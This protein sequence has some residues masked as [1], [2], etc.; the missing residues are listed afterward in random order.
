MAYMDRQQVACGSGEVMQRFQLQRSGTNNIFYVVRCCTLPNPR[1]A[2]TAALRTAQ[3]D[4]NRYYTDILDRHTINCNNNFLRTFQQRTTY[5][6]DGIW[7]DYICDTSTIGMLRWRCYDRASA[8][9]TQSN[10]FGLVNHNVE[11]PSNTAITQFRWESRPNEG[12]YT[13]RCCGAPQVGN[14]TCNVQVTSG[15]VTPFDAGSVCIRAPSGLVGMCSGGRCSGECWY[16]RK[17]TETLLNIYVDRGRGHAC[18]RLALIY[19][20]LAND[21]L[22]V[23][24]EGQ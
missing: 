22:A 2:V 1:A 13:W 12:R 4:L 10:T 8:W 20:P 5:N 19:M 6:P 18:E 17:C 3:N 21:A 9:L 23:A 14:S 15:S 16:W 24:R 7:Y 11:C